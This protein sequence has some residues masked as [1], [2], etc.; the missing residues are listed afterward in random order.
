MT[1]PG[2]AAAK[3][4]S[5][6][7]APQAQVTGEDA[8]WLDERVRILVQWL[9]DNPDAKMLVLARSEVRSEITKLGLFARRIRAIASH[10]T[11]EK[12]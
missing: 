11:G 12:P 10:S 3:K 5:E 8:D 7:A 1:N 9:D 2:S 4:L 6:H